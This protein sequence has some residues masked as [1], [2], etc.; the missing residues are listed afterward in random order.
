MGIIKALL[1][2]FSYLFACFLTLFAIGISFLAWSNQTELNL[3]FLPW[4]GRELVLWVLFGS[5]FG[6]LTLLL[7][8]ARSMRWL[9]F[10][11]S[12]ALFAVLFRGFFLTSY[13][14]S[15]GIPFKAAAYLTLGAFLAMIGAWPSRRRPARY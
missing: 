4:H 10:L 11:W 3:G 6:F 9:F 13:S 12:L 1:R 7:A 8:I 5:L 14:F 15:S 2:V